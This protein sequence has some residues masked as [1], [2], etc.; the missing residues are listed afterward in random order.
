MEGIKLILSSFDGFVIRR[1]NDS[2][3]IGRF[4]TFGTFQWCR[5]IQTRYAMRILLPKLSRFIYYWGPDVDCCKKMNIPPLG[6]EN[7]CERLPNIDDCDS[8][9]HKL[10]GN[11]GEKDC[12][13]RLPP[14]PEK[15]TDCCK[16]LNVLNK[17]LHHFNWEMALAFFSWWVFIGFWR[18]YIEYFLLVIADS[19][20]QINS[21]MAIRIG[22]IYRISLFLYHFDV[23][24]SY[25]LTCKDEKIS[26]KN[27]DGF[28]IKI[29]QILTT[30]DAVKIFS[31]CQRFLSR[32]SVAFGHKISVTF[33][34]I[35]HDIEW[36]WHRI[37]HCF[38]KSLMW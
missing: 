9:C 28:W 29:F 25:F 33:Y 19:L 2:V 4:P 37:S 30:G 12:C 24:F 8:G 11:Y 36:R 35:P 34:R 7:H 6:C 38:F 20:T 26:S 13:Q 31:R 17:F 22:K 1:V 14:F 21:K 32:H 27:G 16:K 15:D 18:F 10:D 5:F 3:S 23:L